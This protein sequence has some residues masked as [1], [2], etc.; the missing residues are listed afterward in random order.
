M[1]TKNQQPTKPNETNIK[2]A[3][4]VTEA[5]VLATFIFSLF[6]YIFPDFQTHFFGYASNMN[7]DFVVVTKIG[8]FTYN[9]QSWDI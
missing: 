1:S 4:V 7:G 8:W 5:G 9:F 2:A 3:K 6:S